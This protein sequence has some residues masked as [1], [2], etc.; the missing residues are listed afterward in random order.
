MP[1][2]SQHVCHHH[3]TVI[4][5]LE[6]LTLFLLTIPASCAG[7]DSPAYQLQPSTILKQQHGK[8]VAL[9]KLTHTDITTAG[10][11]GRICHYHWR[12]VITQHASNTSSSSSIKDTDSSL[13][14]RHPSSATHHSSSAGGTHSSHGVDDSSGGSER[15]G[16]GRGQSS[17]GPDEQ[18]E[19]QG[20][21]YAGQEAREASS[22]QCMSLVCVS[23][24]RLP[25]IT[26]VQDIVEIAGSKEQLVCGFQVLLL[27][28]LLLLLSRCSKERSHRKI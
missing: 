1:S 8:A 16:Q 10:T 26:T 20:N 22:S 13:M 18:H 9:V 25:N 23:E 4:V 27:Q 17:S 15:T 21:R 3:C 14:C 11:D 19:R 12:P 24:E 2:S 5:R 28:L 7:A 6:S